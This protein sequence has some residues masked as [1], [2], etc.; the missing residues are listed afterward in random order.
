LN[1]RLNRSTND[2]IIGYSVRVIKQLLEPIS[3]WYAAVSGFDVP[4][5]PSAVA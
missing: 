3:F 2:D 5:G 1:Y 4:L